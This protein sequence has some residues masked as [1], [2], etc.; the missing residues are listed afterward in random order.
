MVASSAWAG[1]TDDGVVLIALPFSLNTTARPR[2]ASLRLS[3]TRRDIGH[4]DGRSS[5]GFTLTA[6]PEAGAQPGGSRTGISGGGG[7]GEDRLRIVQG[8]PSMCTN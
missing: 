3:T 5:R 2:L 1:G 7:V 8:N 4:R 6:Q